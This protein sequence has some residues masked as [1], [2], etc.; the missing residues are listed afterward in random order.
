MVAATRDDE[1][2]CDACLDDVAALA[3]RTLAGEPVDEI[4]ETVRHHVASCSDCQE[5]YELLLRILETAP[6]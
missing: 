1:V 4:A 2:D 6:E 3:E 5:E